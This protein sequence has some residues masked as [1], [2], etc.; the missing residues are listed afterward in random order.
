MENFNEREK[1][2]LA[3]MDLNDKKLKLQDELLAKIEDLKTQY[4]GPMKEIDKELEKYKDFMIA[5]D[6]KLSNYSRFPRKDIIGALLYILNSI[7]GK[8]FAYHYAETLTTTNSFG[9]D[10][11]VGIIAPK[12][13]CDTFVKKETYVV[14]PITMYNKEYL[15]DMVLIQRHRI[16]VVTDNDITFYFLDG[17]K[18]VDQKKYDCIY[19]FIDCLV[20]YRWVYEKDTITKDEIMDAAKKFVEIYNKDEKGKILKKEN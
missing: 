14:E 19:E 4:I 11:G 10:H 16:P 18:T 7:Y 8:E 15:D 5:R 6:K 3:I 1:K 17:S 9:L 12:D 2:Y 20:D 13:I